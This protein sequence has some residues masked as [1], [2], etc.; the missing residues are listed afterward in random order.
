MTELKIT[1][2]ARNNNNY[3][4]PKGAL[5]NNGSTRMYWHTLPVIDAVLDCLDA[6]CRQID[7]HRGQTEVELIVLIQW[8]WR[9]LCSITVTIP[10]LPVSPN[11][12][13]DI[14]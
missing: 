11:V 7:T 8:S 5:E 13:P 4:S 10:D 14:R 2:N 9:I 3:Q 6:G 12:P 1:L